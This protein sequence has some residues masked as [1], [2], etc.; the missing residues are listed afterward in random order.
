MATTV[1]YLFGRF[2]IAAVYD[3]KK[4]YLLKGL[5]RDITIQN[6]GHKWSFFAVEEIQINDTDEYKKT[7]EFI[8]GYLVKYRDEAIEEVVDEE[9]HQL[10][11]EVVDNKA[12]AKSRFFLHIRTGLIA[13]HPVSQLT[14]DVFGNR[15]VE[16]FKQA[17]ENMYINAELA[18]IEE[19]EEIFEA[20]KEFQRI[21]KVVISLH[22][23][24]PRFRDRWQHQ[25]ERIRNL[26]AQRYMEKL[27]SNNALKIVGDIEIEAK[28]AMADDGYGKAEITG[29]KDG[30][31][32]S[33]VSTGDHPA[34]ADAP[35]DD[36]RPWVV[37]AALRA[38]FSKL[39]NKK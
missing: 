25:D 26:G 7:E 8:V 34:S 23:S 32:V 21:T 24:N 2:N 27:E 1:R 5:D 11:S 12:V 22:P 30:N 17:H 3:D 10:T 6:R 36:A 35:G 16:L 29:V 19:N 39:M 4:A 18:P 33:T 38:I 13:Y 20:I 28:I 14:K 37:L 15:F 31:V 9:K